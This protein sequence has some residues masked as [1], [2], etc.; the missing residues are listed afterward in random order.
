MQVKI[1]VIVSNIMITYLVLLIFHFF[2]SQNNT[3]TSEDIRTE[4]TKP[5]KQELP[6]KPQRYSFFVYIIVHI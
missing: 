4:E 5:D 1:L 3:A 2:S 6:V